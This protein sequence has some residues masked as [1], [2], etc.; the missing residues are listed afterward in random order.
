MRLW[1]TVWMG[2]LLPGLFTLHPVNGVASPSDSL[3]ALLDNGHDTTKMRI[4][5]QLSAF[6]SNVDTEKAVYYDSMGLQLAQQER[7]AH[8]EGVFFNNLGIDYYMLSDFQQSH[9]YFSHAKAVFNEI[10]DTAFLIKTLNNLG[11][12]Y[13]VLGFYKL[14]ADH[15]ADAIYLKRMVNDTLSLARTLNNIAVLYDN[16][17]LYQEGLG[18]VDEALNLAQ[19]IQDSSMISL[20]Y[21]NMGLIQLSLKNYNQSLQYSQEALKLL[22]NNK[23]SEKCSLYN[24][25]ALASSGLGQYGIAEDYFS[26]SIELFEQGL[27]NYKQA[28]TLQFYSGFLQTS[29]QSAKAIKMAKKA[30]KEARDHGYTEMEY[31]LYEVLANAYRD[32][33]NYPM[34]FQ[35][36]E[37]ASILSDSIYDKSLTT[38]LLLLNVNEKIIQARYDHQLL[39]QEN[40][41]Q[42]QQISYNRK[43]INAMA[44]A[45]VVLALMLGII[46]YYMLRKRKDNNKLTSLNTLLTE[47]EVKY[48][49]VVEQSPEVMLIHQNGK[50]LFANQSFYR[51]SGLLPEDLATVTVFDLV[52]P[53]ER[54]KI[55]E[56]ARLH[57]KNEQPQNNYEIR[58]YNKERKMIYLDLSVSKITYNNQQA[59]LTIGMDITSRKRNQETIKKLTAAIEQSPIM[60]M[61][62]NM[63]GDIE[64]VNPLFT[65]ISGF[66]REEVSGQN[67]RILS[68]GQ[69]SVHIYRELWQTIL[70]GQIWRGELLNK[71][72]NGELFWE[73]LVISP[74]LNGQN[75]IGH[76]V[77]VMEDVT[78]KRKHHEALKQR[79]EDLRQANITKDKFF[80]IIA[81]DL[82]NPFNAIIGFA[83]LLLLEYENL[84][85]AERRSYIENINLASNTSY[86]LLENLLEWSRSQTGKI[87]FMP[88]TFDLNSVVNEV[89]NLLQSQ[90]AKKG[91]KLVSEIPFN[92]LVFADKNMIRTVLRNLFSN[93]IKFS[94]GGE[95]RITAKKKKL[96]IEVC[97]GDTGV[98]IP[99]EG[100]EKLFRLDEQYLAEGT[101]FEKGT[102]IGLMLSKEFINKHKGNI[103]V[104][105]KKNMGSKF[106]FTLPTH[107]SQLNQSNE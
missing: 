89:M 67:A 52:H 85:D 11:S 16:V 13:K 74:I 22:P 5:Q 98:G 68:S 27:S 35:H 77:A 49:T 59:I 30:L 47:S 17:G 76:F 78:Q 2:L 91:I 25:I 20:S 60:I 81:H 94:S 44:L 37:S 75:E 61:I 66:T 3:I 86:R 9:F 88:G 1:F 29:G 72:K 46:L 54:E 41:I 31:Q 55:T 64:Y 33:G 43:L 51:L 79:E 100:I 96:S 57:M 19:R 48:K 45:S 73:S 104:K 99:E 10:A 23:L 107:E 70:S 62:T 102:G 80:S 50:I 53:D 106:F 8:M 56:F 15:F 14:S 87:R 90:A 84:S 71:K 7:N 39:S 24:N 21:L 105:S 82:K 101:E 63:A 69:E 65:E 26:K 4:C 18:F 95:V 93:G 83:S 42:E 92:T 58:A 97:V 38:S 12:I 6:Y 103:W 36:L 34:A 28:N 32:L 40:L